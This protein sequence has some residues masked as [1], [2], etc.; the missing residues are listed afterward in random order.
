MSS[1]Y[2]KWPTLGK[3]NGLQG[4]PKTVKGLSHVPVDVHLPNLDS[5]VE[6]AAAIPALTKVEL[7]G[8]GTIHS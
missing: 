4:D 3:S 6:A 1:W 7:G 5:K 8:H 2:M